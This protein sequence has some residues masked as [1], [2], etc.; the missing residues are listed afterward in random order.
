MLD[1]MILGTT[2]VVFLSTCSHYLLPTEWQY[3]PGG[4]RVAITNRRRQHHRQPFATY[5]VY[6]VRL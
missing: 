3:R 4:N 1:V 5:L 2:L 6:I